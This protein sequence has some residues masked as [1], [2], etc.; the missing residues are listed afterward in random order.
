[1]TFEGVV[2]S[3]KNIPYSDI[4]FTVGKRISYRLVMQ[5]YEIPESPI[6]SSEIVFSFIDEIFHLYTQTTNISLDSIKVKF[7]QQKAIS[8]SISILDE[9]LRITAYFER[10]YPSISVRRLFSNELFP[11]KLLIDEQLINLLELPGLFLITGKMASGKTTTAVS[12]IEEITRKK[13]GLHIITIEDPIEYII[14]HNNCIVEQKEMYFDITD[15]N[16]ALVTTVRQ[17]PDILFLGEIREE[18]VARYAVL[19]AS[20]GHLVL[21]TFHADGVVSAIERYISMLQ[22]NEDRILFINALSVISAQRLVKHNS[23]LYP[24]FEILIVTPAIRTLLR[25]KRYEEIYT[26][27][28]SSYFSFEQSNQ[29]QQKRLSVLAFGQNNKKD[30]NVLERQVKKL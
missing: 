16:T 8:I 6:L 18:V 11:D 28:N 15:Y 20:T 22:N 12:L 4:Q 10:G 21:S 1:M 9:R 2:K 23:I 13:N 25:E 26:Y 27:A 24:I 29:K 19:F 3:L 7:S 5:F 30:Y 14:K 17:N